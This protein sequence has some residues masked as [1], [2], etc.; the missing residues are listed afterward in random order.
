MKSTA[1][2]ICSS[3]ISSRLF[4][5]IIWQKKKFK[6]GKLLIYILLNWNIKIYDTT[7]YYIWYTLIFEIFSTEFLFLKFIYMLNEMYERYLCWTI[8]T[9]PTGFFFS[10]W[11]IERIFREKSERSS[12]QANTWFIIL[13]LLLYEMWKGK[14][15]V[16]GVTDCFV[17][18]VLVIRKILHEVKMVKR[19]K[20]EYML[21]KNPIWQY[22]YQYKFFFIL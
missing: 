7:S 3:L 6:K 9:V 8:T 10:G 18:R 15:L 13:D 17:S 21:E 11:K 19:K 5:W 14:N 4:M 12:L 1:M 16:D 22:D 20:K 2:K